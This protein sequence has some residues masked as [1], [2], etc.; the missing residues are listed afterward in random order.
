MAPEVIL[1]QGHDKAA[2]WWT[3]GILLYELFVGYPPFEG[4]DAMDLYT[5]IVSGDVKYP[6]KITPQAQDLIRKLLH[7]SQTER[8]GSLKG[9]AEDVKRCA[10]Y[11]KLQWQSL[12][13]KKIEAPFKPKIANPLDTSNFDQLDDPDEGVPLPVNTKLP[14]GLFDEFT[15]LTNA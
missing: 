1:N 6:K 2:D 5:K 15:A 12:L 10:F 13:A 9:G 11:K 7:P 14:K 8:L 4:T 3:M